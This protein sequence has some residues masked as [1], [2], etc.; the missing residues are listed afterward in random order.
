MFPKCGSPSP[1]P[2]RCCDHRN[3]PPPEGRC[4]CELPPWLCGARRKM[5]LPTTPTKPQPNQ[6]GTPHTDKDR[7]GQPPGIAPSRGREPGDHH[8]IIFLPPPKWEGG[9]SRRVKKWGLEPRPPLGSRPRSRQH[10]DLNGKT[11]GPHH[12]RVT[13]TTNHVP[14]LADV[15]G[16]TLRRPAATANSS[17]RH[18][19]AQGRATAG[20]H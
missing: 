1:P 14:T 15:M 16:P 6:N 3:R 7:H 9:P 19:P 12:A 13:T 4:A 11:P 5:L 20:Q 10:S 8:R 18:P 2:T 17:P